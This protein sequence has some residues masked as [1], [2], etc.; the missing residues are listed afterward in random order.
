MAL[1]P[2]GVAFAAGAALC[3]ALYIVFGK[4]ASSLPGGQAVA[5][6]MLAAS[7]F[8]VPLGSC[9][10]VEHCCC[11]A[12]SRRAR[13]HRPVRHSALLAGDAGAPPA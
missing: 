11:R 3:W 2:L 6:G 12:C 13:S 7:T 9:M 4:R 10:Q 5:W 8:T 1:D